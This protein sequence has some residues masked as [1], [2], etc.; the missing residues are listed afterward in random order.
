MNE[1]VEKGIL[2]LQKGNKRDALYLF[3]SALNIDRDDF[4]AWFWLSKTVDTDKERLFCLREV[5]SIDSNY[6]AAN[7]DLAQIKT[8][9]SET[10]FD[11]KQSTHHILLL[12]YFIK[13]R[14]IADVTTWDIGKALKEIPIIAIERMIKGGGLKV[15][16]L[17][18]TISVFYKTAEIKHLLTE[19]G[20]QNK[21]TKANLAKILIE[22]DPEIIKNIPVNQRRIAICTELGEKLLDDF[23]KRKEQEHQHMAYQCYKL[24][25]NENLNIH[26]LKK[27]YKDYQKFWRQYS[28][29]N[30]VERSSF[31]TL[32]QIFRARPESLMNLSNDDL[33]C[34]RAVA[35]TNFLWFY[36]IANRM[37]PKDFLIP[38]FDLNASNIKAANHILRHVEIANLLEHR[39]RGA[40]VKISL[41]VK[42]S[43]CICSKL[44]GKEFLIPDFPNLPLAGCTNEVGCT[45]TLDFNYDN[46]EDDEEEY[47][48]DDIIYESGKKYYWD[49]EKKEL[50]LL[51]DE[52]YARLMSDGE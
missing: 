38:G 2:A 40:T 18:S 35:I 48:D 3:N 46:A 43:D 39:P 24:L 34:A 52:D 44:D 19:R 16:D 29:G 7:A 41:N 4:D 6:Q 45:C 50:R 33:G 20:L 31:H 17:A 32:T 12:K 11:W 14:S 28:W 23:D 49:G 22:N 42:N 30:Y 25:E 5:V 13:P 26:N 15:L 37:I 27:A 36:K 9:S 1:Y 51:T 21:G 10:N 8:T 47:E